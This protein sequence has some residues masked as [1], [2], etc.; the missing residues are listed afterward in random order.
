MPRRFL[1]Q[2][3]MSRFRYVSRMP[4][5]RANRSPAVPAKAKVSAKLCQEC[6]W[7][8]EITDAARPGVPGAHAASAQV[9]SIDIIVMDHACHKTFFL[10]SEHGSEPKTMLLL[11]RSFLGLLRYS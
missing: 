7:Q 5:P 9:Q 6:A 10:P 3:I 11:L 1:R 2:P 8:H 4:W